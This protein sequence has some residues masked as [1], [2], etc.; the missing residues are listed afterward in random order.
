MGDL[1]KQKKAGKQI[2]FDSLQIGRQS[3]NTLILAQ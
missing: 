1:E 3:R 2:V